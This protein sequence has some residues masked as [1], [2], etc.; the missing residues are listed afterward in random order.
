MADLHVDLAWL[1]PAPDTIRDQIKALAGDPDWARSARA[2]AG[3]GLGEA[4]LA[5]LG[6]AI[7]ARLAGG[8]DAAPLLP[9]RLGLVG[10]GTL[11]L[12]APPLVATFARHGFALQVIAADYD[13]AMPEALNPAGRINAARPDAVL[14]AVDHHGLPIGPP[15]PG[16][17]AAAD[18]QVAD[19]LAY[20]DRLRTGFA[21]AGATV[22]VATIAAPVESL[23]GS[24]DRV[25]AGTRRNVID[26]INLGLADRARDG[27]LLL[28]DVA[29]LA[30]TIGLA[31]WHDPTLWNI[32]K[33]Q[34]PTQM[35]PIWADHVARLVAASRGR[36]RRA[37]VLDLDNT[38]WGG[39]IGDDG[40]DGIAIGEGD[41]TGEAFL[42]VQRLALGLRKRGVVLAVSSKNTDAVARTPFT[43]HPDMALRLDDFA[44]FQANWSDKGTNITTI[45]AELALG[46]ESFVFLDDNPAERALVRRTLPDVAVPELP[47]DPALYARTLAAA[48]YFEMAAFSPEDTARAEMYAMNARRAALRTQV[49]DMAAYLASLDMAIGFAPF[50]AIGRARIAQLINKSNQ[51][52][53]TTRRYT[54]AQVEAMANDPAVFTCQVRLTDSFGDNGMISVI[55]CRDTGVA[56]WEIDSWLMSC[57]V[58]GRGVERAVLAEIC[59]HARAAGITELRGRYIPSAKNAMVAGHYAGLGFAPAGDSDGETLW[60]RSVDAPIEMPPMRVTRSFGEPT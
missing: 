51:F 48:G 15:V 53:L 42:E 30:E 52:N 6:K 57:R 22:I 49:T 27:A 17:A 43:D 21:A 40:V 8:A 37:L 38:L 55:I 56:T 31:R 20:F 36:S 58:L 35:V 16:D 24:L 1:P 32:A 11:D 7:A 4:T 59:H 47:A 44:L 13:Q 10:N 28:L 3:H 34:F 45:A 46:L 54:D 33:L 9:F 23:A 60:T 2:I 19:A 50:D 12:L 25:L 26:R 14:V 39:V 41:A 29:A 18:G 5:R